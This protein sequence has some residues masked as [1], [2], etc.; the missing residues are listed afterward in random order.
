[1]VRKFFSVLSIYNPIKSDYVCY[2]KCSI[3]SNKR[4]VVCY[5]S[6]SKPNP[7]TNSETNVRG[8]Y[9]AKRHEKSASNACECTDPRYDLFHASLYQ[10]IA[11]MIAVAMMIA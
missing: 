10:R 5:D 7:A 8:Q 3:Q 6:H 9:H 11:K 4:F 2:K 1:M